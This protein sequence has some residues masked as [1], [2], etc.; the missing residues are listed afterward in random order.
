[1]AAKMYSGI[2]M[3]EIAKCFVFWFSHKNLKI[4]RPKVYK[5]GRKN[6]LRY[7]DRRN[8][9][10]SWIFFSQKSLKIGKPKVYKNGHKYVFRYS[11]RRNCQIFWIFF[12]Q[13]NLR[14]GEHLHYWYFDICKLFKIK[15]K[16]TSLLKMTPN[17]DLGV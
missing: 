1:M 17:C 2:R 6:V 4:G 3:E 12:S 10:M 13:K 7:S 11:N 9:Q 14:I 8:C 5:N 16:C 15:L